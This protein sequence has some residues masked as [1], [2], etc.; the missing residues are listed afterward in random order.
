MSIIFH[1]EVESKI[2]LRVVRSLGDDAFETEDKII[3]SKDPDEINESLLED[4]V[5][6]KTEEA[7]PEE[8]ALR[9][10]PEND[11]TEQRDTE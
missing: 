3:T 8:E 1:P 4:G 7:I 5:S 2:K 6:L 9:N 10:L 11:L